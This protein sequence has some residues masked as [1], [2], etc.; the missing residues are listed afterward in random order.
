MTT[1]ND[2][3][4]ET[5][6]LAGGCFWCLDAAYQQLKGVERVVSGYAGGDKPDPTYEQVTSGKTSH[7]ETVQITYDPKIISYEDLLEVFWIIHNPTTLNR[8]GNDYGSQYRSVIFY[9]SEEQHKIAQDSI[10][11]VAPL[12]P[13]PI[14]TEV[15][16]LETFYPAEA[17]HQNYFAKNPGNAYCQV[18]INPKLTKLRKRFAQ[19]LKSIGP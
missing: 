7:A 14:V 1:P 4:T 15:V 16:P 5:A 10:K 3:K 8:Q 2:H 13:D 11:K 19:R 18:V 17:Y 9:V 6:T 12:W